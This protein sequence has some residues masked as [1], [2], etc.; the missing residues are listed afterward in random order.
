M[1]LLPEISSFNTYLHSINLENLLIVGPITFEQ[2]PDL[3]HPQT[4]LIFK[5]FFGRATH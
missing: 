4:L 1:S 5:T 2:T 3:N